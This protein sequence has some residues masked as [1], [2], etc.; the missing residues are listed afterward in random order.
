MRIITN[1]EAI[2]IDQEHLEAMQAGTA[3]MDQI[4]KWVFAA[5]SEAFSDQSH[6]KKT[7]LCES[8]TDEYFIF[9]AISADEVLSIAQNWNPNIQAQFIRA[10]KGMGANEMTPETLP[11]DDFHTYDMQKAARE[12][13]NNWWDFAEH[14][15]YLPNDQGYPYFCVTLA[16]EDLEDILK[17]PEQYIIVDVYVKS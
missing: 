4:R 10:L 13:D 11:I 2:N 16:K 15:V 17:Q 6:D 5:L 3:D 14:S 7:Y 12:L 9:G 1:F 8:Y